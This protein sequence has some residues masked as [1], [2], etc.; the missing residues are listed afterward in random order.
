MINRLKTNRGIIT[1]IVIIVIAAIVLSFLGF[2]PSVLWNEYAVPAIRWIWEVV[3]SVISF[4]IKIV[5][6][7][8][9]MVKTGQ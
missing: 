4:L 5:V 2:N 9:D 8:V 1:Q 6:F 7:F 3:F